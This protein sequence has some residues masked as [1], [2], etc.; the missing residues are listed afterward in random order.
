MSLYDSLDE[1]IDYC[2]DHAEDYAL[3]YLHNLSNYPVVDE[4]VGW[5]FYDNITH[6]KHTNRGIYREGG[7]LKDMWEVSY[8]G[9]EDTWHCDITNTKMVGGWNLLDILSKGTSTYIVPPHK[10]KMSFF[11]RYA[12]HWYFNMQARGGIGMSFVAAMNKLLE[13]AAEYGMESAMN[14]ADEIVKQRG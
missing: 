1:Y 7:H 3:Q 8:E 9:E 2:L 14:D 4:S 5:A 13:D 6:E 10:K 12:D 11:S